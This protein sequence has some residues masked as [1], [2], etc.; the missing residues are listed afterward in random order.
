MCH[1]MS[2]IL[3][4]QKLKLKIPILGTMSVEEFYVGKI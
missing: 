3:S 2:A 4:L 1:V